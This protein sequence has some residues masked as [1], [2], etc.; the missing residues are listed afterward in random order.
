[1][2]KEKQLLLDEIKSQIADAS[3]LM[4]T[5]YGKLGANKANDLRREI[6]KFGGSLEVVKKRVFLKAAEELGMKFELDNLP[7]HV[8]LVLAANDPIEVTKAV[9]RFGKNSDAELMLLGGKVEGQLISKDD[10]LRIASLPSKDEMRSQFLGLL[11]AP[12]ASVLGTMEAAITSV[13]YCLDNKANA[14]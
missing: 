4:V 8:G 9:L 7:G 2:N 14:S 12:M 1:M 5:Q 3:A 13:I 6:A 10:A 11:E